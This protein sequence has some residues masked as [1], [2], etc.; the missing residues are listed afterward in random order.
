MNDIINKFF[1][2]GDK[3]IPEIHFRQ[4][5]FTYN[6]VDQLQKVKK[7]YKRL[8]KPEIQ[9]ILTKKNYIKLVFNMIWLME[10]LKT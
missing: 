5:G 8:N 10:I 7:E 4:P 1:L 6:V 3:F 2:A 9:G